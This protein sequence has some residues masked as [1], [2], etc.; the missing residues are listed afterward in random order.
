MWVSSDAFIAPVKGYEEMKRFYARMAKELDWVP[1]AVLGANPQ[2]APA[3]VE[4]RKTASNLNGMPLLSMVSVGMAG[5][6]AQQASADNQKQSSNGG[7]ANGGAANGGNANSGN[8]ITH[9]I[10][11]LFGK[12]KN[13]DDAA[14]GDSS[15]NASNP[16]P[17]GSLM[18]TTIEVTSVSTNAVDAAL[19]QIPEGYKQI[20]AKG[21]Q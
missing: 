15:A 5:Q 6:G 4:Y 12:K 2:I 21:V 20:Q 9:G 10:G 11:G 1:G 3:M 17:P 19:F 16:S 13:K 18:D 8:P 14:Q 7:A